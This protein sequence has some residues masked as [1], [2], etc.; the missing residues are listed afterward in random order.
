MQCRT[1]CKTNL[2]L[3]GVALIWLFLIVS[4]SAADSS[5]A[6]DYGED[7]VKVYGSI[8]LFLV[9]L[10]NTLLAF[11]YVA[12]QKALKEDIGELKKQMGNV[13][14][15]NDHDKLCEARNHAK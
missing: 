7:V 12:G 10:L 1:L 8:I 3:L 15:K 9:G 11:I 13:Y 6:K 2:A 14:S 4:V 5:I